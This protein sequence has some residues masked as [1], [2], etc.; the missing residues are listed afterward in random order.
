MEEVEEEDDRV[1][2]DQHWCLG[3]ARNDDAGVCDGGCV[4]EDF[5][6][7]DD[8]READKDG[9]YWTGTTHLW[10]TLRMTGQRRIKTA[11][12]QS[13]GFMA[14]HSRDHI[15][16]AHWI[17]QDCCHKSATAGAR[18]CCSKGRKRRGSEGRRLLRRR[19]TSTGL[20]T[21]RTPLGMT[22]RTR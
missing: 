21:G 10:G 11:D 18:A 16:G 19:A 7:S 22:T 12:D 17:N 14:L 20:A 9:I 2:V 3:D 8:A 15:C 6:S 5:G 13:T 1:G 4:R